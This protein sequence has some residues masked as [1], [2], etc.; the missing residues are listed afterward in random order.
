MDTKWDRGAGGGSG[1]SGGVGR[2]GTAPEREASGVCRVQPRPSPSYCLQLSPLK[3]LPNVPTRTR[4]LTNVLHARPPAPTV[5]AVSDTSSMRHTAAATMAVNWA[6][7]VEPPTDSNRPTSGRRRLQWSEAPL[8]G[9]RRVI[10]ALRQR[11]GRH[12]HG[13]APHVAT[14]HFSA[15]ISTDCCHQSYL[16]VLHVLRH[17]SQRLKLLRPPPVHSLVCKPSSSCHGIE[18]HRGL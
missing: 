15:R 8:Q 12:A 10:R 18:S 13:P 3:S 7:L 5:V 17:D 4:S 14:P 9:R 16:L 6:T 2:A 11:R 1:R